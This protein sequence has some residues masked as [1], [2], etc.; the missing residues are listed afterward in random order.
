MRYLHR[1]YAHLFGYFW[2]PCPVCGKEFGGH[3]HV[4]TVPLILDDG[5]ASC[6]CSV[7]CG[8]KAQKLNEASGKYWP[9]RVDQYAA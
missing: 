8:H 3:E 7:E 9:I 4:W 1:L 2:L 6:V 5:R